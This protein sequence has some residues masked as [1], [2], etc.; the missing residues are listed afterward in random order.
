MK[1]DDL[2]TQVYDRK[3]EDKEIEKLLVP[4]WRRSLRSHLRVIIFHL[5]HM[6]S[7]N[8]GLFFFSN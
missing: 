4:P 7:L 8:V 3:K 5:A 1:F 2:I 6:C